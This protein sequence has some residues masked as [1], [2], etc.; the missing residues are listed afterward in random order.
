MFGTINPFH[1]LLIDPSPP[2]YP[3]NLMFSLFL[4]IQFLLTSCCVA[5]CGQLSISTPV[6]IKCQYLFG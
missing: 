6:G 4:L 2:T 3:P 5:Y 1:Q